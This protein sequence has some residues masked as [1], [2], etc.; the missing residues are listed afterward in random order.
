M[1]KKIVIPPK[2]YPLDNWL[3]IEHKPLMTTYPSFKI[4]DL[5]AVY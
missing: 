5:I 2:L 3:K 4:I 1:G